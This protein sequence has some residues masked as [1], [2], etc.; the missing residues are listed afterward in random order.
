MNKFFKFSLHWLCVVVILVTFNAACTQTKTLFGSHAEKITVLIRRSTVIPPIKII[1]V[2][3]GVII[4]QKQEGKKYMYYILTANHSLSSKNDYQ[5]VTYDQKEHS[6]TYDA[7]NLQDVDDCTDLAILKF[8]SKKDYSL[9]KLD[10]SELPPKTQI[11]LFGWANGE[12]PTLV[13]GKIIDPKYLSSPKP[14][15]E[16]ER[17]AFDNS[18]EEE[19]MPGMSG[20]PILNAN[21]HLV[22][23]YV[24][25]N[26]FGI[27]LGTSIRPFPKIAPDL[28]RLIENPQQ[29]WWEN[30]QNSPPFNWIVLIA[31]LAGIGGF[32]ITIFHH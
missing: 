27:N 13:K 7:E 12:T 2:A 29:K 31:A 1:P 10:Y 18:Q 24:G 16:C 23:I 15:Q 22:G 30:I 14:N 25:R 8:T 19:P 28:S 3:S 5:I 11:S 9:V 26:L 4:G 32:I 17:L 21:N 20:G 6:V